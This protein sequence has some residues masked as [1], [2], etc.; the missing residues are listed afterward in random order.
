MA[1]HYQVVSGAPTPSPRRTDYLG[2]ELSYLQ[3]PMYD[4]ERQSEVNLYL[5]HLPVP[6]T[7]RFQKPTSDASSDPRPYI[8]TVKS[9][10]GLGTGGGV[11]N[12]GLDS[13]SPGHAFSSPYDNSIYNDRPYPPVDTVNPSSAYHS[14]PYYWPAARSSP[15]QTVFET[16]PQHPVA[17]EPAP[18]YYHIDEDY[19]IAS[20]A[21]QDEESAVHHVIKINFPQPNHINEGIKYPKDRRT[22]F[23]DQTIFAHKSEIHKVEYDIVQTQLRT[24]SND[25]DHDIALLTFEEE[26]S[27]NHIPRPKPETRWMYVSLLPYPLHRPLF[28]DS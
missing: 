9:R 18:P 14:L 19:D 11:P 2:N 21:P 26:S 16:K 4:T 15:Y 5:P 8:N 24:A 10:A 3:N 23:T 13:Q 27:K 7:V 12:Y 1:G 25:L 22:A 20:N 17:M 28:A 6:R